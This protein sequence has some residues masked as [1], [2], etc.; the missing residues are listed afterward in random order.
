M[1]NK[2]FKHSG[3]WFVVIL[4]GVLLALWWGLGFAEQ[5][6][7]RKIE[8][9]EIDRILDERG[10]VGDESDQQENAEVEGEPV[11]DSRAQT[12]AAIEENAASFL[13]GGADGGDISRF[14][15]ASDAEVYVEYAVS[16]EVRMV[17]L[18]DT[19]E[20]LERI[21]HYAQSESGTW[22]LLSGQEVL[23]TKPLRDLYERDSK[24]NWIARN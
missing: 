1:A 16:G 21:A 23:F 6:R 5:A 8:E 10:E 24:G 4:L 13:P 22:D 20:G 9:Q 14:W 11:G 3:V 19:G 2:L 18:S 12:I 15:F 7:Q 17:F